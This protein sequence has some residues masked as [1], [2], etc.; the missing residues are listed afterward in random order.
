MWR[1]SRATLDWLVWFMGLGT[2]LFGV[3]PALAPRFF[4]RLFGLPVGSDSR[5]LVMVRSV[6]VRD[7]A[8]GIGMM[9]SA[10]HQRE[11]TPWLAVRLASDAGDSLAVALAIAHGARNPRFLALG[12]LAAGATAVG[13]TLYAASQEHPRRA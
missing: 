6:G 3:A 8:I 11:Y 4:A 1:M 7:A 5:L 10:R 13:L 2:V 9:H 12:G